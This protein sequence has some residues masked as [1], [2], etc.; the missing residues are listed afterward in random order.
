MLLSYKF[1]GGQ[2]D[3]RTTHLDLRV[4]YGTKVYFT[5]DYLSPEQHVYAVEPLS[6]L[7]Y[8]PPTPEYAK[9][10]MVQLRELINK[11]GENNSV[12]AGYL[13]GCL[14]TFAQLRK[15]FNT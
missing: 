4:S 13:N 5:L 2:L 14:D 1:E 15:A 6:I 7:R 12:L 9:T 3:G 10:F 8:V 11:E